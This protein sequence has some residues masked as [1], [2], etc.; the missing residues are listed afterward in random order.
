[1][2]RSGSHFDPDLVVFALDVLS[3][4]FPNEGRTAES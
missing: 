4:Y 2:K 3:S 1:M